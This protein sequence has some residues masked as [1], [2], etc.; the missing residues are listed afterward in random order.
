MTARVAQGS[1]ETWD[2]VVV[3]SG[4]GGL[5][6]A[7]TCAHHG[8]RVLVVEKSHVYGGSTAVSGGAVWIPDNPLMASAG[9]SDNRSAVLL[10]L[11]ATIQPF[12]HPELIDAFLDQGP[13]MIEF[14]QAHTS[15]KFAARAHSPD[16][17]SSLPGASMGGRTL[18]PVEFDG[19]VLGHRF[20]DLR[21]PYPQFMVLGGMMV[22][23]KD[24]E[25]LLNAFRDVGS[26]AYS[27][28][29]VARYARDRLSFRRGTRLVLGN[30]LAGRLL[31]SSIDLGVTL[32]AGASARGLVREGGRIVGVDIERGGA[33]L[34]VGATRGVVLAS[35]GCAADSKWRQRTIP[36]ADV[37]VSLSPEGSTGDGAAMALEQ[38]GVLETANSYALFGTPVSKLR[39]EDGSV[40]A[41]PHL[42]TDR[43]KPGV[44][45]VDAKGSRFTDE[46]GSYHAFVQAMHAA[47]AIPAYL[48]CD[49]V[50]VQRY[51]LGF[52]RPSVKGLEALAGLSRYVRCGYLHEA[53]SLAELARE[54]GIDADNLAQTVARHNQFA[55]TGEDLEFGRGSQA[56]SRYLGDP[57]SRPNPCLAPIETPPFY[58]VKLYPGDIGSACGLRTN[59]NAQ[60]LAADA[61]PIEGLYACGNDMNSIMMGNY[62]AAGITLGPALT[63]GYVAGCHLAATAP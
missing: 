27:S 21:Q 45:A 28:R 43:Q 6:A 22:H 11:R 56:Y 33:R 17:L 53:D 34:R 36:R 31:K 13:R 5:T 15:V 35:G 48:I 49:R 14:M 55:R 10:Y 54:L 58:A 20:A 19:R 50:F 61:A 37:H 7:V 25:H 47:G 38:G 51:G 59:A 40:R 2:V 24:T 16:Y 41:F 60:V 39:N 1:A 44:I 62:P 63:F 46:S 18:D 42:V 32:R 30:A 4:A 26:F 8:L 29:M 9:H 3:G 12:L 23:R 57:D 52:V